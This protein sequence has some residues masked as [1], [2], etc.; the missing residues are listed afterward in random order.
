MLSAVLSYGK[1]VQQ[2][3]M[4]FFYPVILLIARLTCT[5]LGIF[6]LPWNEMA[7][8]IHIF[9]SLEPFLTNWN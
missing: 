5:K 8:V 6:T 3:L 2:I 9:S 7:G 4:N 1:S